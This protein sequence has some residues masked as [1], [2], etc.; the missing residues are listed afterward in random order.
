MADAFRSAKLTLARAG[1]H[2]SEFDATLN[3]FIRE[4]AWRYFVE[5]SADGTRCTHKLKL[6]QPL[7]DTLPSI[8]FD[9][10][11]N[12]RAVLDQAGYAAAVAGGMVEPRSTYFP[13][14]GNFQEFEN[15]IKRGR[16]KDLPP[17]ILVFFR[18]FR[19]YE[20]G[21]DTLWALNKLCN[22]KKH[23]AL[24]P[25]RILHGKLS[26]FAGCASGLG[27]VDDSAFGWNAEER[28]FTLLCAGPEVHCS[29]NKD[30]AFS[31]AIESIGALRGRTANK[32]LA[33]MFSMV[34]GILLG[35]EEECRQL[36]LVRQSIQRPEPS[37]GV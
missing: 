27:S 26:I 5:T 9:A 20:G 10:A 17:G 28:E 14:G 12:L 3:Q 15:T 7:P 13:F 36:G 34:Q 24:V 8:L 16:C 1:H 32:V 31:V 33:E 19:A 21:N 35:T 4:N 30:F 23:C 6:P 2:I 18:T 37:K 22:T 25:L 11:N 29:Y